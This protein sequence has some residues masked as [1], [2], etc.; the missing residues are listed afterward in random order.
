MWIWG[1]LALKFATLRFHSEGPNL[2]LLG[3]LKNQRNICCIFRVYDHPC[4]LR[5]GEGLEKLLGH[6]TLEIPIAFCSRTS[7]L[8]NEHQLDTIFDKARCPSSV[9]SGEC[10]KDILGSRSTAHFL[11]HNVQESIQ[12]KIRGT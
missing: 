10:S 12:E 2:L 6:D 4:G 3:D 5:N 7:L 8:A 1:L 11:V 9:K